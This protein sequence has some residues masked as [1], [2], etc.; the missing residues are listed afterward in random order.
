MSK[1]LHTGTL[2]LRAQSRAAIFYHCA[3]AYWCA[4]NGP[5]V[6]HEYLGDG[7]LLIGLSEDMNSHWLHNAPWQKADGVH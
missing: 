5:R 3:M 6:C 7:H 1:T 4:V 2:C